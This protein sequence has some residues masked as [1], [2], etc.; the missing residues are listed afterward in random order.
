M[1]FYRMSMMSLL[2]LRK[3]EWWKNWIDATFLLS[4]M[5]LWYYFALKV[6]SLFETIKKA[7]QMALPQQWSVVEIEWKILYMLL[8]D[9]K[10]HFGHFVF[11]FRLVHLQFNLRTVWYIFDYFRK[12]TV[13]LIVHIH[14]SFD[15][16]TPGSIFLLVDHF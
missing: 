9:A 3:F 7:K 2:H 12:L 10:I 8:L 15:W 1:L 14:Y 5:N 4:K 16:T 13:S 11:S 6:T